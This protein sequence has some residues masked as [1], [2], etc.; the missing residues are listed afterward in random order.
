MCLSV[1]IADNSVVLFI[2]QQT[3]VIIVDCVG[4]MNTMAIMVMKHPDLN[5]PHLDPDFSVV[6]VVAVVVLAT[7]PM[8]LMK[9][10]TDV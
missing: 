5:M 3:Y 8:T 1:V 7:F 4:S 10:K 2:L 6:I 9:M